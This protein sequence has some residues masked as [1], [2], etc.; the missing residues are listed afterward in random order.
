MCKS[1]SQA[2]KIYFNINLCLAEIEAF[3]SVI[4]VLNQSKGLNSSGRDENFLKDRVLGTK[5]IWIEDGI[6]GL[7]LLAVFSRATISFTNQNA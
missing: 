4:V 1:T 6:E 7:L 3:Y 5:K 2:L